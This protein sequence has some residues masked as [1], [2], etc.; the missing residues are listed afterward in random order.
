MK[1]LGG[2]TKKDRSKAM[3]ELKSEVVGAVYE[4]LVGQRREVMA[5]EPGRGESM[6]CRDD[7][8]HQIVIPDAK[9]RGIDPGDFVEVAV[10]SAETVY[11]FGEPV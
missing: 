10:T 8:Y 5:V 2:Q 7:A 3:S 9:S 4:S 6:K 1:G 11:A